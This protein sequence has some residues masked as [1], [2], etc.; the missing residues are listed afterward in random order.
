MTVRPKSRDVKRLVARTFV[1]LGA[2]M[3]SVFRLRETAFVTEGKCL[4]RS[5]RVESLK[6]VWLV[7]E[8][9]IR[10]HDAQGNTLRTINLFEEAQHQILAA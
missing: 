6:A 3:P 7:E 9:I 10:F 2:A 1:E 8:G 4:A 5:Y